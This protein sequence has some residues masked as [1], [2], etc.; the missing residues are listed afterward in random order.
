[1]TYDGNYGVGANGMEWV[2]N[3][4]RTKPG[5]QLVISF[6]KVEFFYESLSFV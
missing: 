3:G 6:I 4:T 2:H 5:H 1:M